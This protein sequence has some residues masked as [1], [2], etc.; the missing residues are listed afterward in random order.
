MAWT[1]DSVLTLAPDPGAASAGQGLAT[2]S[3][4]K[5]LARSERAVWGLCQGSGKDP[6]QVRVDLSEPAFKCSCPSRK[7]PCKHGIALM[8]LL[9]KSEQAFQA[10]EE[11]G[12]VAD[13]LQGRA[14]R[15]QKKVERVAAAAEK[16]VD[17]EAQ[18]ARSSKREARVREG[19]DLCRAWLDDLVRR[20]LA[21]VQAESAAF[22]DQPAARLV[23]AQAPGLSGAVQRIGSAVASGDGWQARALDA[24][25]RL[26][27]VLCAAERIESLPPD[28]AADVRVAIGWTQNKDDALATGGVADRW[29][30]V[31]QVVEQEERLRSRR[32]WLVGRET[33]RPALLLGFAAGTQLLEASPVP[34]TEFDGEVAF[35][36]SSLALRGIV[37]SQT[38]SPVVIQPLSEKSA[39]D[40]F[41]A[42]MHAYASALARVPW[43]ARWPMTVRG[44]RP[45]AVGDGPHTLV[46][47]DG[48]ALPILPRCTE[49]WRLVAASGGH[50]VSV[51]GEWD[52]EYFLPL[53][54][55]LSSGAFI[56]LS[57][58]WLA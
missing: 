9:V 24:V 1:V 53:G 12:W 51:M 22:W 32:T 2:L 16:P 48:K 34:G 31:G 19:V 40:G 14:D 42:A 28:L 37:K 6:Y 7:F 15:G 38:G 13:W 18:T 46:D 29:I 57:P 23:D 25:A 11:P 4:W 3:K 55:L 26:H 52:G 30:V 44:V 20:G 58:R 10:A 41:E 17:L 35:Y 36:P 8:L 39:H 47:R 43:L 33:G 49:F 21:S 27:L 56:D 50:E 54:M 45:G 5:S